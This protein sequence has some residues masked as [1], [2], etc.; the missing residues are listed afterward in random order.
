MEKELDDQDQNKTIEYAVWSDGCWCETKDLEVYFES[1]NARKRDV[2]YK[3]LTE[4]V[5]EFE[6]NH[7]NFFH[8]VEYSKDKYWSD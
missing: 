4:S 5:D 6:A 2:N 1:D 8:H 3:I 7:G